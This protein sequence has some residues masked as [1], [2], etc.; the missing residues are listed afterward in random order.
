MN[1]E[2][3]RIAIAET[4]LN[5]VRGYNDYADYMM[6]QY[7][8]QLRGL[9]SAPAIRLYRR[10]GGPIRLTDDRYADVI[11]LHD[12]QKRARKAADQLYD[13]AATALNTVK[14]EHHRQTLWEHFILGRT[15]GEIAEQAGVNLRTVKRWKK[16]GLLALE[17]PEAL[18]KKIEA[19]V[20]EEE[21]DQAEFR[22]E[23]EA[24]RRD[25]AEALDAFRRGEL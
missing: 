7:D 1:E 18:K 8:G 21:A 13:A 2:A 6:K 17:L 9:S 15:I 16:Q 23:K 14:D 22:A 12:R 5:Q 20:E 10:P 11:E 3:Q 24:Q 4:F 19:L 25:E